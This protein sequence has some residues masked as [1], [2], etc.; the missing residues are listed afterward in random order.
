MKLITTIISFA[1]VYS[2]LPG[3]D[4]LKRTPRNL[5]LQSEEIILKEKE[6]QSDRG[7]NSQ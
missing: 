5:K 4:P 7:V 3:V 2:N 1:I 6:S